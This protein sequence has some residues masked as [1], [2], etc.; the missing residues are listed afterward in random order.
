MTEEEL[1]AQ[2]YACDDTAFRTLEEQYRPQLSNY[3]KRH[4]GDLVTA[5]DLTAAVFEKL[6]MSK[7]KPTTEPP[8]QGE[9]T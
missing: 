2:Y 5:D 7:G 9:T 8:R 3:F 1:I 6:V 4:T